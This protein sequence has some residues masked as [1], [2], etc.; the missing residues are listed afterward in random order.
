MKLLNETE[1]R[2]LERE[3]IRARVPAL[4]SRTASEWTRFDKSEEGRK[5]K[6][7]R[8]AVEDQFYSRVLNALSAHD[9][10]FAEILRAIDTDEKK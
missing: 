7:Q 9:Q 6:V 10:E 4:T 1:F 5:Y 8:E 2:T 3:W